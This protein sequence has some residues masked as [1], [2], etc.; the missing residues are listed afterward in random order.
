MLKEA[1]EYLKHSWGPKAIDV[2]GIHYAEQKLAPVAPP[3]PDPLVVE[4]L[5]GFV[6]VAKAVDEAAIVHVESPEKVS[7]LAAE[8][9]HVNRRRVYARAELGPRQRFAFNAF[10]PPEQF[11]I[12][13]QALFVAAEDWEYVVRVASNL[14]A[15]IVTTST[16]DGISQQAAL[17]RGV[18]LKGIETVRSRVRLAPYRTFAEIEQPVSDFI[19]R[20][21]SGKEGELPGCGLFEADGGAWRLAAMLGIEDW[22]RKWLK[23]EGGIAIV[24]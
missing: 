10:M 19:L 15:E 13:L 1:L 7:L 3:L 16:D 17:A 22:L 6:D 20:L 14:T 2:G 24:A 18:T 12:A 4:T 21:R 8:V 11:V 5:S 9:D 23:D